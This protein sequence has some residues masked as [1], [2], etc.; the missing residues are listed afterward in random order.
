[1]YGSSRARSLLGSEDYENFPQ[2]LSSLPTRHSALALASACSLRFS[3][4][5]ISN[6]PARKGGIEAAYR[7]HPGVNLCIDSC[8]Q[9]SSF[10]CW[11]W[12]SRRRP[13]SRVQVPV[14]LHRRHHRLRL[15]RHRTSHPRRPPHRRL[16]RRR[17]RRLQK[18][19]RQPLRRLQAG[20]KA[21]RPAQC[22]LKRQLQPGTWREQPSLH[23]PGCNFL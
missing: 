14:Q 21:A 11:C 16:V 20:R 23:V 22:H 10:A 7:K 1:M 6:N 8:L 3:P 17:R 18:R 9:C 12:A 4:K 13:S 19:P 15:S 2:E 5:N